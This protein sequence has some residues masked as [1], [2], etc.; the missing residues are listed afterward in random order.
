MMKYI[1]G[2]V[3]LLIVFSGC[4]RS[5]FYLYGIALTDIDGSPFIGESGIFR[6]YPEV[7]DGERFSTADYVI[8]AIIG[9]APPNIQRGDRV[10]VTFD[11][12]ATAIYPPTIRASRVRIIQRNARYVPEREVVEPSLITLTGEVLANPNHQQVSVRII[13]ADND[14]LN[15]RQF[16]FFNREVRRIFRLNEGDIV[17]FDFYGHLDRLTSWQGLIIAVNWRVIYPANSDE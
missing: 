8:V 11:G 10:R 13:N 6:L 2:I 14:E 5:N 17:E 16:S 7:Y 15:G 1:F 3:F 12:I 9:N 4:N